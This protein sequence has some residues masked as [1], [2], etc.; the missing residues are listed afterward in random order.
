MQFNRLADVAID[1]VDGASSGDASGQV[2]NIG[3]K[4]VF[5]LLDHDRGLPQNTLERTRMQVV[6]GVAGYRDAPFLDRMLVL[7]MAAR[8]ANLSPSIILDQPNEVADFHV[9][10]YPILSGAPWAGKRS[11]GPGPQSPIPNPVRAHASAL[12]RRLS[13]QL[14]HIQIANQAVQIVGMQAQQASGF[15]IAALRLLE[16]VQDQLFLGFS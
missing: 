13:Q 15:G 3:G 10:P 14:L 8:G 5:A 1:V 4:I 9:V 7:A 11:N 16:G 2:R 6:S 12:L